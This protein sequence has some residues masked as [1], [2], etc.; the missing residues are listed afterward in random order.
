MAEESNFNWERQEYIIGKLSVD[1]W[2]G[3]VR[4]DNMNKIDS[5]NRP[6]DV[7]HSTSTG[8]MKLLNCG[9]TFV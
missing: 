9:G 2:Y 6:L 8:Q 1:D 4:I 7:T 5:V 3:N